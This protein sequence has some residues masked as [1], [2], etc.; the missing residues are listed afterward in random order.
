[1]TIKSLAMR[2]H[3]QA[4]N[5]ALL[6]SL[7][8]IQPGEFDVALVIEPVSES[9]P[10]SVRLTQARLNLPV[11]DLGPWPADLSLRWEEQCG[12]EGR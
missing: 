2:I 4:D 6:P 3:V 5:R 10:D 7:P 12:D 11:V 9:A 1:M 8:A